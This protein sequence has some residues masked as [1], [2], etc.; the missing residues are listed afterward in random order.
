MTS[1]DQVIIHEIVFTFL[2]KSDKKII[3]IFHIFFCIFNVFTSL[4]DK[5]DRAMNDFKEK[6]CINIYYY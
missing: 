1:E 4:V 5:S 2:L 6:C 3:K